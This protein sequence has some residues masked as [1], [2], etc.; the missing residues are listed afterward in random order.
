MKRRTQHPESKQ[1][2]SKA[3]DG[4]APPSRGGRAMRVGLGVVF[5]VALAVGGVYHQV[6]A[7]MSE[8]FFGLGDQMMYYAEGEAQDAPR[9]LLLNG[10]TIRF[11]S[12]HVDQPL[13]EVLDV[14]ERR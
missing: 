13:R 11:S 2:E 8:T 10:Q 5:V 9:T 4:K 7:Q 14:F 3:P 1:P 6:R 12:G